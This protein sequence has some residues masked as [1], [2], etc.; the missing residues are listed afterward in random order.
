MYATIASKCSV[1]EFSSSIE[2]WQMCDFRRCCLRAQTC[3]RVTTAISVYNVLFGYKA[4]FLDGQR[5]E[6]SELND[7]CPL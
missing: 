1:L 7:N 3:W 2:K 4:N 5:N 6:R